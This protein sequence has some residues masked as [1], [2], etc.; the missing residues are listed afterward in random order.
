MKNKFI[1]LC[2]CVVLGL[3]S[4]TSINKGSLVENINNGAV[5]FT[6]DAVMLSTYKAVKKDSTL[7]DVFSTIACDLEICLSDGE[8]DTYDFNTL[9]SDSVTYSNPSKKQVVNSSL[10]IAFSVYNSIK[11]VDDKKDISKYTE[12]INSVIN[13]INKGLDLYDFETGK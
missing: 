6:E 11:Q 3:T 12:F 9:V 5:V 2:L 7:Y 10:N 1:T 13:G 8:L 4:C